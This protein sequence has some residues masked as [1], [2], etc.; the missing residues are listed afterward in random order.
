[1]EALLKRHL[2]QGILEVPWI[3]PATGERADDSQFFSALQ[4][5]VAYAFDE[6]VRLV[7]EKL[8]W[9]R[10]GNSDRPGILAEMKALLQHYRAELVTQ[11]D[12]LLRERAK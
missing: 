5:L 2:L 9:L 3:H 12:R 10:R 11:S 8:K 6:R 7:K 1:M 4:E